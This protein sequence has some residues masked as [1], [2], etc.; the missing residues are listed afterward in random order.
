MEP[1]NYPLVSIVSVNWNQVELT[2]IMLES[3]RQLSYPNV[4]VIVVDNG[5]TKGDPNEIKERYPETKLILSERNLGFAG[6]NNLAFPYVSGKYVL[7][8]NNDTEVDPHFLEPMVEAL[9][10]HEHI[11]ILSPKIYFFDNP[12]YLQYAGTTLINPVTSRGYRFGYNQKDTGQFKEGRET[13]FAN[14]A[15]MMIRGKLLK[16]VGHLYEDYFLYYEEHDYCER[17]RKAGYQIYFE[18]K[19]KIYHKVSA[20]TG[21]L[22][23]LK[24]YYQHR[25]RLLFQKRNTEGWVLLLAKLYY[26]LIVTPKECIKYLLSGRFDNIQAIMKGTMWNVTHIDRPQEP[27]PSLRIHHLV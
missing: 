9:E 8:L 20:S 7:L 23:P 21:V 22:S 19:S 18:P 1:L 12:E 11:G 25:N 24:T 27:N 6:G 5:S 15:C 10:K 26:F 16:E 17:V 4:E 13:G 14:G 3:L 2:C